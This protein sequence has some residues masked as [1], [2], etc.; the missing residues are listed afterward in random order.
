MLVLATIYKNTQILPYSFSQLFPERRIIKM[1]SS[2]L[3]FYYLDQY[4]QDRVLENLK[5]MAQTGGL[6]Q[7]ATSPTQHE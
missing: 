6:R 2:T 5:Y 1:V 7:A 4:A 3:R